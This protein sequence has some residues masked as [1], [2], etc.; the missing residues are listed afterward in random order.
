MQFDGERSPRGSRPQN[1]GHR[2]QMSLRTI[3]PLPQGEG[4]GKGETRNKTVSSSL[5]QA[6][7]FAAAILV[8]LLSAILSPAQSITFNSSAGYAGPGFADGTGGAAQFYQPAGLAMDSAGNLYVAD[9]G[10]NTIRK[11]TSGGVVS[12]FAGSPG[13]AGSTDGASALFNQPIGVAVDGAG[14]VY[15][16]DSGNNTIRKI[17]STG[18]VTTLAGFAGMTGSVNGTGTNAL[19]NQPQGIAVDTATNLYVADYGNHTIR[20]ISPALAVTTL[21]G[22]PGVSGSTNA[23]GTNALFYQPQGV[24]VDGS[25]NV[26]VTDTANGAIRKISP[27]G[28]VTTLAGLPGNLGASD[29]PGTNAQFYQ[30]EG[31][32]LDSSLNLYVADYF[33]QTIRKITS[34]GVVTTLAGLASVSGSADGVTNHARFWGPLGLVADASANLCVADSFNGTLRKITPAG[35]VTT[36][37]GSASAGSVDGANANA[38][39]NLPASAAVDSSGDV[40]VADSVNSTIRKITAGQVTTFAGSPGVFGSLDASGANAVFNGPQSVAVDSSGNVYVA[41]T[42]NDTIRKITTAGAVSTFAGFPGSPGNVNGQGT[43]AQFYHPQGIALDKSNNVYVADTLNNTIRVITPGGLVSTLAGLSGYFGSIDGTNS[44]ARFNSPAGIALDSSGNIYVADYNNNV[45][46]QIT[47]AGQ[48]ATLAGL[49][50]V[51][52]SADGMN[53][54]ARFFGPVGVAVDAGGNVCV[55]D[56]GNHTLR[57]LT[58]SGTNWVVTTVAGLPGY[59]GGANGSGGM[60]RFNFPEGIALDSANGVYVADSAN[61]EVRLQAAAYGANG[62]SILTDYMLGISPNDP[63]TVLDFSVTPVSNGFQALFSPLVSGRIYQLQST[64][65]LASQ[66]WVN[67]PNLTVSQTGGQGAILCTNLTSP[68]AYYR[69]SVQLAP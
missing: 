33:N 47:P 13:I 51:W 29:G 36:F 7:P 32:A 4:R 45:I 26:Y 38:R 21:A 3:L 23:T 19:F 57:L 18:V 35:V 6:A 16:T 54:A 22:L 55:A 69:L 64:T 60:A 59:S 50:G 49:A 62:L 43:N 46:R 37:A 67:V 41:D 15:V 25:F 12:T 40:Y 65:N 39:F 2:M 53:N 48:T 66:V 52:G 20:L 5:L 28:T 56:S 14:N 42:L 17:T 61:N 63:A 11:I 27:G 10:N 58:P 68:Q 8:L 44:A 34:A 1:W 30:P 24:A 31:I 9:S